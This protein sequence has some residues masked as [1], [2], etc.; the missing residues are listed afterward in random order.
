[1]TFSS[2]RPA[3]AILLGAAGI[4]YPF[5]V[6]A[7]PGRVASLCAGCGDTVPGS[8]LVSNRRQVNYLAAKAGVIVL[9]NDWPTIRAALRDG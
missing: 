1:M 7:A 5:L 2:N 8:G 6:H 3:T 4:A 9:G